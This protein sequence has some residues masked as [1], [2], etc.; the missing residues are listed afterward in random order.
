MRSLLRVFG[1]NS[2]RSPPPGFSCDAKIGGDFKANAESPPFTE[3][4]G[5]VDR[6]DFPELKAAGDISER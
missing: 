4:R 2:S 3:L 6:W 5:L 1:E